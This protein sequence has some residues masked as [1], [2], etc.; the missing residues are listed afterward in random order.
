MNFEL[1]Q[2]I[3]IL[4]YTEFIFFITPIVKKDLFVSS[5]IDVEPKI[6]M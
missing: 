5:D 2:S 1:F 4:I 6:D 3:L